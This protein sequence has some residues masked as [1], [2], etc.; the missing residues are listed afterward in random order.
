M[1]TLFGEIRAAAARVASLARFVWIE[2]SAL[3]RLARE[4]AAPAREPAVLDPA[5]HHLGTDAATLAYVVTLDA[6]NFGSGW[7]PLLHKRPGCS[8]YFTVA[9]ALKERFEKHGPW[10]ARELRALDA[11]ALSALLGQQGAHADISELMSHFARA[12]NDLGSLLERDYEGD[13]ARLVA[14]A[15]GNAASLVRRLAAM[16]L[17]RDVAEYEGASVPLYKRAQLCAADLA[18]AFAG[19]GYGRFHDLDELTIFADNLVPHVLRR[20]GVLRYDTA[21]AARIDRGELLLAGSPEEVEIRAVGLHAVDRMVEQLR[22]DAGR[23]AA[24]AQRLDFLL[25]NRGQSPEMKAYPRHRARSVY[26]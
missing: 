17:Y 14:S 13:F 9:T 7:F 19:E 15:E 23:Q 2:D 5:H 12:L 25:W 4:L 16:P 10:S 24:S 26:Y 1:V 8:G 18:A 22:A 20:E 21:L 11:A 6:V 3:E